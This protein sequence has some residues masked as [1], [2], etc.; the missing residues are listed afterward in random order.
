MRILIV[1]PDPRDGTSYYRAM[2]PFGRMAKQYDDVTLKIAKPGETIGWETLVDVDVVFM[3]RPF[4]KAHVYVAKICNDHRIPLVVDYDDNYFDI[5]E[6]NPA[7]PAYDN[8]D[9]IETIKHIMELADEVWFGTNYLKKMMA[10]NTPGCVIRN[11]IDTALFPPQRPE[12]R[13][14]VVWRGGA[15]HKRNLELYKN[16]IFGLMDHYDDHE[17]VFMGYCPEWISDH[18]DPRRFKQVR[19]SS[20]PVYMRILM[21][22]APKC[23]IVPMENTDFNKSRGDSSYLEGTVAGCPVIAPSFVPSFFDN[24]TIGKSY[25]YTNPDEFFELACEAIRSPFIAA[26]KENQESLGISN[27]YTRHSKLIQLIERYNHTVT[28]DNINIATT[29]FEEE[30]RDT[31]R[32]GV[33]LHNE[34]HKENVKSIVDKIMEEFEIKSVLDVGCGNGAFLA[35]FL[36]R[37]DVIAHGVDL[38]PF[39]K[40]EWDKKYPEAAG[41]FINMDFG[42]V[43]F[44]KAAADLIMCI[45]VMEHLDDKTVHKWVKKFSELGKWVIFTSVPYSEGPAWDKYWGHLNLKPTNHWVE[46]FKKY[47]FTLIRKQQPPAPWG[48]LFINTNS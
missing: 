44:D 42:K 10:T 23:I 45:E 32:M 30:Y 48:M 41:Y 14:C 28:P 15:A 37:E 29:T 27:E 1:S 36:H 39:W 18:I 35:E 21:E 13:K 33:N 17:F 5:K 20:F 4:A 34:Q 19:F 9:S 3:Q 25:L 16:E 22:L 26:V 6:D 31:F 47:G 46:I 40:E 2:G 24:I 38:N 8:P 7:F 12:F 43:K 11:T